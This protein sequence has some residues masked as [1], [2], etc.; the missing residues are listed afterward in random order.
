VS[1]VSAAVTCCYYVSTLQSDSSLPT[2]ETTGRRRPRKFMNNHVVG[3]RHVY[4]RR[5]AGR[6]ALYLSALIAIT[7]PA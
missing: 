7:W 1:H 5:P 6:W 4:G 3:G 2:D